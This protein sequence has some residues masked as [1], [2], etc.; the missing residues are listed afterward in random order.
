MVLGKL[1]G[2]RRKPSFEEMGIYPT[3]MEEYEASVQKLADYNQVQSRAQDLSIPVFNTIRFLY[4][5]GYKT[6]SS[7][8]GAF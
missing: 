3:A 7:R 2:I 4:F 6:Q 8:A 1:P 5:I